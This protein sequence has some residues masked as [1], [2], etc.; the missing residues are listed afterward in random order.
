M[1]NS[2]I[3]PLQTGEEQREEIL[4]DSELTGHRDYLEDISA[5]V[6]GRKPINRDGGVFVFY[7]VPSI[8]LLKDEERLR[9]T[10][11]GEFVPGDGTVQFDDGSDE[12][13][14]QVIGRDPESGVEF[15]NRIRQMTE[16]RMQRLAAEANE[17]MEIN[18]TDDRASPTGPKGHLLK[19]YKRLIGQLEDE[20]FRQR[21]R[22][23][24]S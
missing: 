19:M 7:R 17:D 5:K 18:G 15:I 8:Q 1:S 4:S 11:Y 22:L 16:S 24:S 12:L 13:A 9:E 3:N 2:P 10:P 20:H 21:D 6:A 23:Q 14:I